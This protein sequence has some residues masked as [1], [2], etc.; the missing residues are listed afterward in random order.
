MLLA[1]APALTSLSGMRLPPAGKEPACSWVPSP[2]RPSSPLPVSFLPGAV[3][4]MDR[5]LIPA[6]QAPGSA[7]I[8]AHQFA[9]FAVRG[10][11][12]S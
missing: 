8:T 11:A 3:S 7:S 2:P 5:C 12:R 9:E 4:L 10:T 1:P 6:C